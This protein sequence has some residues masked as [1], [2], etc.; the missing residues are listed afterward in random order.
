MY[1]ASV[2]CRLERM[3]QDRLLH[4]F[5]HYCFRPCK[6]HTSNSILDKVASGI[7][8]ILN[9]TFFG[10]RLVNLFVD[11]T[12]V[13]F[14]ELDLSCSSERFVMQVLGCL[15]KFKWECLCPS[16]SITAANQC[17]GFQEIMVFFESSRN[18]D[19]VDF[20]LR[21]HPEISSL[22]FVPRLCKEKRED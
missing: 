13:D 19:I 12:A 1:H 15:F 22:Y 10:T 14:Y 20:V 4:F 6:R 7:R 5:L 2:C 11:I 21:F 3:S 9:R 8:T 18:F 16:W 17:M